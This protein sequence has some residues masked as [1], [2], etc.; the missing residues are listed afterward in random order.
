MP[1]DIQFM[2]IK[3]AEKDEQ[4]MVLLYSVPENLDLDEVMFTIEILH[5]S[6]RK[7]QNIL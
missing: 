6:N 2:D 3:L 1:N 7:F 4:V 5:Q